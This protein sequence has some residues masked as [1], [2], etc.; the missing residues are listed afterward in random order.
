M[1]VAQHVGA[2]ERLE[3]AG[4]FTREFAPGVALAEEPDDGT[5]FG[6]HRCRLLAAALVGM[7]VTSLSMAPAAVRAVGAQLAS[8]TSTAC[9]EAAEAALAAANP[10]AGREAVRAVL[11]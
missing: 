5:P 1:R 11:G 4:A 10:A 2:V 6:R 8:V 3:H 7:G 9:A